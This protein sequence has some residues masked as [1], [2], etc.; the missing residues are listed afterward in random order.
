MCSF[1]PNESRNLI[2]LC[3]SRPYS[4]SSTKSTEEDSAAFLCNPAISNRVDPTPRF[5][6]GTPFASCR[7]ITPLLNDMEWA[8]SIALT[9]PPVGMPNSSVV[10]LT[11][12]NA[13][14]SC[15]CALS[16]NSVRTFLAAVASSSDASAVSSDS[17][18][19]IEPFFQLRL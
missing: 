17:L 16:P 11:A 6:R 10:L 5:L 18:L 8:S 9:S 14:T 1:A 4:N 12:S 15:F 13:L 7:E 3:G 19:R 2:I